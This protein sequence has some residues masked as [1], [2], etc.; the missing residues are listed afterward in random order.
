MTLIEKINSLTWFDTISKN[1]DILKSLAIKVEPKLIFADNA[2]AI[3]GG[4]KSK[5][6]YRTATGAVM[7]VF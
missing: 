3:L 1:R 4:L 5:D 6:T 2:S 7:I